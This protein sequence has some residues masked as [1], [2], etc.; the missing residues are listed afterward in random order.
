MKL[1][2]SISLLFSFV[3]LADDHETP[4]Y[5]YEPEVNKAEYYIG[6]F[7]SNKDINDLVEWYEKFAKWTSSTGDTYNSMTVGLLQPYFHTDMSTHDVMWVNTWPTPSAQFKGLE[8]WVTGG[9]PKLLES[10]PVTNSRQVD[11]W[12]WVISEPS[13]LDAGNMMWAT[14]AD[15]S[16]EEGYDNRQVYDMYKDFAI[17]AQSQGD[18]VGRKMIVPDSG[19]S[20]PDGV[21]F[22]RLMYTSS[23]SERGKN[24][25]LFYSK[26]AES[27]AAANLKGFSCTNARAYFGMSLKAAT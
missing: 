9:G 7:N 5:K 15:C 12:Q 8:S 16:L 18:T 4:E 20:L 3:V 23:I 10:L 11:T 2:L 19:Y 24:A 25:E 22:I 6:T 27:E 26:I 21:D 13:S 17:Y 14:Y 1:L